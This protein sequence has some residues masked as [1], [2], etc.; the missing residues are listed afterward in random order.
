MFCEDCGR[1]IDEDEVVPIKYDL[2]LDAD[3]GYGDYTEI[4]LCKE[5][6]GM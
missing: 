2:A 3:D 5:C 4:H 1:E 6:Q